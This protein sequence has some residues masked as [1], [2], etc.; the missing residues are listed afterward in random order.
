MTNTTIPVHL[1]INGQPHTLDLEPRVTLLDAL[2]DR[3]GL[4]GTKKGC[5]HGQC[6][7]CTV[8]VDGE[9]VLACLTLAAQAEGRT[10]TTIEGL[11][12]EGELH[13]VQAAFL[14]QDAFQ[15]GYCTSGQIMS[16]VACI[17]EGH[18]GSDDEIRE[19]MAGNLCRCG[20]YPHIIAAV[21]QAALEAAS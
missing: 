17:R 15:C 13:P 12:R 18:A 4:T 20:A 11:A 19:Y 16:A 2:R 8:H 21:R 7:A 14:D 1:D 6:G 3:L 10:V 9:R 5:D